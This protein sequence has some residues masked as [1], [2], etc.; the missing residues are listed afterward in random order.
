[1]SYLVERR[2]VEASKRLR[3]AREELAVADEQLRALADA[4][5]EAR[6]RSLVSETPLAAKESNEAQRHVEAMTRARDNLATQVQ[7]LEKEVDDLLDKLPG[8]SGGG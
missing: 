7:R 2:L 8:G 4:A 6:I 3:K 1:M 5:D